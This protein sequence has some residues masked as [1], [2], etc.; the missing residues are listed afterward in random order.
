MD[1]RVT[2]MS[3]FDVILRMNWLTAH[4]VVTDCDCRRVATY[5]QDDICVMFQKDKHDS[6]PRAVYDSKWHGQLMGWLASLTMEDEARQEL[7]LP[8]VVCEYEDVFSSELSGL[9][10][11][12]DL[13]FTIELHP[14][15]LPIS[16]TSHRMTPIEL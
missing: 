15:T 10:P 16:M 9:P 3:E 13:Y 6:L 11:Y 2:D 7:N 8:R 14:N 4:R 5:T 1:L 12:R